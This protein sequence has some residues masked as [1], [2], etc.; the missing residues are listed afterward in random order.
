MPWRDRGIRADY[1]RSARGCLVPT[2][3]RGLQCSGELMHGTLGAT[4]LATRRAVCN[5]QALATLTIASV[6]LT[7]VHFEA[8]GLQWG[9][10]GTL[11]AAMPTTRRAVCNR[12]AF[13]TLT[14]LRG[15]DSCSS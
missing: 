12:Q 10:H 6:R 8:H 5:R 2:E 1:S 14:S 4:M 9:A 11:G 15:A 3:A 13:E 7:R